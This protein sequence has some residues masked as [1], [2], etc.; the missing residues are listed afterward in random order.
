MCGALQVNGFTRMTS[1]PPRPSLHVSSRL[2]Q[3]RLTGLI[4]CRPSA[5]GCCS[6]SPPPDDPTILESLNETLRRVITGATTLKP[7]WMHA[8]TL[9][10]THTRWSL[11]HHSS[12]SHSLPVP[13]V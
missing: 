8:G 10:H 3:Q 11:C 12:L 4:V 2:A 5:C 9:Q 6:T 1:G 13:T 7:S